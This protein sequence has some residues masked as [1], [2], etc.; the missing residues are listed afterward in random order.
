MRYLKQLAKCPSTYSRNSSHIIVIVMSLFLIKIILTTDFTVLQ[1]INAISRD[2]NNNNYIILLISTST[3]HGSQCLKYIFSF[4]SYDN[5]LK[6]VAVFILVVGNE[7]T[8]VQGN[9]QIS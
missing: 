1:T 9:E 5:P 7:E 3:R 6:L 8:E 4:N 2:N